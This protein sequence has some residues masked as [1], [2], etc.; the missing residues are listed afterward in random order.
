MRTNGHGEPVVAVDIDGTL[1]G[2]HEWFLRFAEL[3]TG[4]KMPDTSAINDGKPLHQFMGLTKTQYR[5][6]KLA[7]RQGGMKR[8]MP[9]IDNASWLISRIR[10]NA[11]MRNR[12]K[13]GSCSSHGLGA[14]VWIC[15]TRPYLRLDNID[16]DTREWLR[17]NRIKYDALLFDPTDGDNKYRELARQA[18][19]RVAIALEDL[20]AQALSAHRHGVPIVALRRQPYNE[21]WNDLELPWVYRWTEAT[22]A[23]EL[24]CAAI[25]KWRRGRQ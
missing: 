13:P 12:F 15:T 2:Y 20:P 7:Y 18:G 22:S 17:R 5:E 6:V 3:Y 23:Y 21:T 19:D 4:K 16:P 25:E 24:V 1:A 8:S 11:C 14:E 9:C 10:R